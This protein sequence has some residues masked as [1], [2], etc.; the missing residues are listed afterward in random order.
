MAEST[1]FIV[2]K[3]VYKTPCLAACAVC[4]RKLFTPESYYDDPYSAEQY[5]RTKFDRH[6]CRTLLLPSRFAAPQ[7]GQ[8]RA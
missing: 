4:Q 2:L 6:E 7:R 3:R 5:L 1:A 8:S